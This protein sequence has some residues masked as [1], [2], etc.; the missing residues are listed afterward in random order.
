MKLIRILN[1]LPYSLLRKTQNGK[2]IREIDGLRFLAILPVVLQH[3]SERMIRNFQHSWSQPIENNPWAFAV[4]RGSIGVLLFF[5]ISGFVLS[6]PFIK[7]AEK[8]GGWSYKR[9]LSRRITRIEPPYLI[10]MTVFFLVLLFR[11]EYPIV[12]LVQHYLASIFYVHNIVYDDFSIINPVAWSLEI[13]IQF[14][15]IAPFLVFL[16]FRVRN[17]QL[18]SLVLLGGTLVFVSLQHLMGWQYAPYKFSLLGQLPHFLIGIW[19][20]DLYLNRKTSWRQTISWDLIGMGA[21][22]IMM[23]TWTEEYG[24]TLVFLCALI[25]LFLSA[26][27]GKYLNYFFCRPWIVALGGMCYTIYLIHLPLLE[28]VILYTRGI[29]FTSFYLV[30]FALQSLILLPV[31]ATI[32]I[33]CYLLLERPFMDKKWP[34]KFIRFTRFLYQKIFNVQPHRRKKQ[35][36]RILSITI[37]LTA[38]SGHFLQ[39]QTFEG[40]RADWPDRK[41]APLEVL[42]DRAIQRDYELQLADKVIEARRYEVK[43]EKRSI[44]NIL[45]IGGN[46]S[47]GNGS[48]ITSTGNALDQGLSFQNREFLNYNA[49]VGIGISMADIF[50]RKTGIRL[51][52]IEVEK[53]QI[54]RQKKI[55]TLREEVIASYQE[56]IL[57]IRIFESTLKTEQNGD[58]VFSVADKY[59]KEGQLA[60]DA[61]STALDAE[62]NRRL[63]MEKARMD[64]INALTTLKELTGQQ[65]Y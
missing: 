33:L 52:E 59:F 41:L 53:A 25:L 47:Y 42:I 45:S 23:Y 22:I 29:T 39:A 17:Y 3:L 8:G 60:V 13:E 1:N 4:S 28:L 40:P 54:E 15:L 14:Y 51:K 5:A 56:V 63:T 30:N 46:I 35:L 2:I 64:C 62:A 32:S 7:T 43:Q 16:L 18:R 36:L 10:W 50:N 34:G 24:K 9:Y 19:L 37:S 20:A 57:S 49:G 12:E 27:R 65:I 31:I 44:F 48:V 58:I 6:I 11:L 21:F 26:F 38:T 61:Y 55:Q